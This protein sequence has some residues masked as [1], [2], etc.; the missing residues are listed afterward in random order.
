MVPFTDLLASVPAASILA[1]AGVDLGRASGRLHPAIVHFPIALALVAVAAE[2][3]R[4]VSRRQELSALTSPLLWIAAATA[5]ISTASGWVN[6]SFEHANDVSTGLQLHR[7]IGTGT[8]AALLCLAWWC[9]L[10][11]ADLLNASRGAV[12]QLRAFRWVALATGIALGITGHFGGDIV[13]GEGYMTELVFPQAVEVHVDAAAGGEVAALTAAESSFVANVRPILEKH[14]FECH[15]PRKQK[16]GLRMDS[17]AWLFNGDH[18]KWAVIPGKSAD[19][20]LM[21]RV[22]LPRTDADAMPPEGDGLNMEEVAILKKWIDDGAAYPAASGGGVIGTSTAATTAAAA[23]AGTVAIAG[24]VAVDVPAAVRAKAETASKA[25]IA[26]GVLVQPVAADSPLLD[27]NVS[28]AEPAFGDADAAMLADVAPL[29]A[30][31]NLSKCALTDAG[32]AKIGAMARLERLRLDGTGIG[33]AGVQALGNLA[34]LESI[35]L[36]GT[37]VSA[38]STAWLQGQPALRRVYVWQS[39]LDTPELT[40]ALAA[41]GKLTVVGGDL[42]LAKPTT[43]PMPE[44]P[45]PEA[46]KPEAPKPEAPKPDAPKPDEKK[47]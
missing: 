21:Q 41:G 29:V 31:L 25:L 9:H 32:L 30:N 46:P 37:K 40:K 6:A 45:K 12:A 22:E 36:V 3:W 10:L 20:P 17:K 26:R 4:V 1:E 33:D 18:E 7:W 11:A 2:W 14:C 13:H 15:G 39:P 23:A 8:T 19:S 5:V 42:P 34:H 35:N 43:P 28:R 47:P 38:A 24:S 44:D 27:I 16:G